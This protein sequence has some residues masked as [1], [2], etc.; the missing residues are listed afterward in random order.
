MGLK[1]MLK[2]AVIG[3]L[4]ILLIVLWLKKPKEVIKET[5]T[6]RIDT[7]YFEK[8]VPKYIYQKEYIFFEVPKDSIIYVTDKDTV[9]IPVPIEEKIYEDSTY[10]C[11]ISGYNANLEELKVYQK[12]IEHTIENTVFKKPMVS[13]SLG[14]TA[15]YSPIYNN[16]DVVAGFTI[17]IPIYSLYLK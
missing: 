12:T 4:T 17:S 16:F 9:L 6:Q 3:I 5:I 10:Y 7:I 2:Y 11:R 1:D 15:G 14:V 8:P 13:L